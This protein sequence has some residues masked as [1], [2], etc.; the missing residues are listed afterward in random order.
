MRI[1]CI[2]G[3]LFSLVLWFLATAARAAGARAG[4]RAGTGAGAGAGARAARAR[5]RAGR[6]AGRTARA[7]A[8]HSQ[9]QQHAKS[10]IYNIRR[11]KLYNMEVAKR[12]DTFEVATFANPVMKDSSENILLSLKK[13]S[14]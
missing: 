13:N 6:R 9:H 1:K 3:H 14:K 11:R 12:R 5:P 7:G 10:H 2:I 8:W 4:T